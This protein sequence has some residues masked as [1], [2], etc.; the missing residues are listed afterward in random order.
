MWGGVGVEEKV[1]NVPHSPV[2][3]LTPMSHPT[4]PAHAPGCIFPPGRAVR[5]QEGRPEARP[6]LNSVCSP[7]P[8]AATHHA[9]TTP[10]HRQGLLSHARA[11]RQQLACGSSRPGVIH[12]PPT[13]E[14]NGKTRSGTSRLSTA[15][16]GGRMLSGAD[17]TSWQ[18]HPAAPTGSDTA[19][20]QDRKR[21]LHT[22]QA[23]ACPPAT[24]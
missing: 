6:P 9:P 24:Q 1:P 8:S 18:T 20:R 14:N 16:E 21:R 4:G 13:A 15:H 23:G 5:K 19:H 7:K 3:E 10:G 2:M 12:N 11:P 22:G 17:H